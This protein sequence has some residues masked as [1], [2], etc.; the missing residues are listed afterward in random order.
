MSVSSGF[1]M[2]AILRVVSRYSAIVADLMKSS[3]GNCSR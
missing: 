3:L 1:A 2:V